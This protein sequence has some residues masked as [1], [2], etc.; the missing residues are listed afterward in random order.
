[1]ARKHTPPPEELDLKK[2]LHEERHLLEEVDVPIVTVSATYRKE[3]AKKYRSI[4]HT[5]SDI[6]YSRA[7]YSMAEAVR[8][9]ALAMDLTSHLSDPTNFVSHSDWKKVEMTQSVGRL[10]ARSKFLKLLKD[11]MDKIS[12]SKLPISQAIQKPLIYLTEKTSRPIISMHYETGK[13]LALRGKVVVQA[14]T[15][16]HVHDQYLSTLANIG[17]PAEN[18]PNIT[19]AVFDEETK[20]LF[21]DLAKSF[22]KSVIDN[23]VVVTGPF[24]DPRICKIGENTKMFETGKPVNLGITTGGIGTNLGEI[25][26]VLESFAPLLVPPEKIRLFLYAG[27]HKDFRNFFEN[28]AQQNHIRIGNLDDAEARIRILHEDS[29]IDANE[30]IIKYMF[31][32]V[33]GIITKPSGDMTYDSAAAGCFTLFL[34]PWGVQEEYVQSRFQKLDI[35]I[36]LDTDNAH[37]H[38]QKLLLDGKL[39]NAVNQTQNLPSNFREGCKNLINLQQKL[40]G[41]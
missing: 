17:D 23:Q 16:P 27:I 37:D 41:S 38:F 34:A 40:S 26:R 19:Y 21:F 7:H 5:P 10:V 13:T 39:K 15:D 11:K 9:Q 32:W 30:N 35:G 4:V 8:R 22:E 3:L 20:D 36:D 29:V 33:H 18:S 31:P 14:I 12:R 28:Y 24:V 1:M 2:A 25:K 6:I